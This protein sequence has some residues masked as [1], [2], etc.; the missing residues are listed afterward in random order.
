MAQNKQTVL[1]PGEVYRSVCRRKRRAGGFFLFAMIAATAVTVFSPRTYFSEGQLFIRLGREN[2]TLD[3]TATPGQ[4]PVVAV[5]NS[6]ES[7]INTVVTMLQSRPI[8]EHVVDALGPETIL[9]G[10][11]AAEGG[12]PASANPIQ[13]KLTE[14]RDGLAQAVADLKGWVEGL[15]PN[16]SPPPGIRDRAIRNVAANLAVGA[17]KRSDVVRVSFESRSPELSQAVVSQVIDFYIEQHARLNRSGGAYDFFEEQKAAM[18]ADLVGKQ[19]KLRDLRNETGPASPDGQRQVVV[20][21]IARIEDELAETAASIS[22][23]KAKIESLR[24]TLAAAS[25][26]EIIEHTSGIGDG[27]T[28]AIRAE[29]YA[30]RVQEEEAA[31]KYTET[32]PRMMQLRDQI[33][34][35]EEILNKEPPSRVE[36][37]EGPGQVFQQAKL[38]LLAEEPLQA[39][40]T[41]KSEKLQTQL[42]DAREQ[43]KT[44]NERD[45]QLAELQREVGFCEASY[46]K[47]ATNFE[48]TR[49]NQAL[50]KEKISNINV[51]QPATY[52]V[53]P[54]RPRK[55]INLALG[56]LVGIFGGTVLAL[57]ADGRDRPLLT[58]DEVESNLD[59]PA[60]ASIPRFK[61]RQLVLN[62]RN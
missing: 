18:L 50:E 16:P 3:P 22:A 11:S 12:V 15:S 57:A 49:I 51:L 26:N 14:A 13:E 5:P 4:D 42:A 8:I 9:D 54:I 56:F 21:R 10:G 2:A 20:E 19:Q 27:G 39:S 34:A 7:E 44:L 32:H 52:E 41:A 37:T 28:D 36:V 45:L 30:L 38:A 40:L 33:A 17:V 55:L 6:R 48:Q 58:P 60:L 24:E 35:A 1:T 47:Y 46:Q 29:F 23:G 59:L 62:G 53:K 25:E 43:W 61:R 31:S